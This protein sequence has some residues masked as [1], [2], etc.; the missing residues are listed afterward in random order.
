MPSLIRNMFETVF[1]QPQKIAVDGYFSTFTSYRPAFTTWQGG[2][3]EAELTRS[4]IESGAEHASKLKPEI[5]GNACQQATRSLLMQP[6]PWQTTPQF[7]KRIWTILQV[8]DTC[9][10]VRVHNS[11]GQHC[12]YMPVLPRKVEPY[13]VD[14]ELWLKLTFNGGL[15]R[16]EPWR[17]V[18]VMTRHQ[19]S[20]DLFGDSYDALQ[21]TLELMKAEIEAEQ[22]AIKQ[23]AAVRFIGKFSQILNPEDQRK[24]REEFNRQNLTPDNAGGI[25]VYDRAFETVEQVKPQSY[26]V[27]PAQMERIEKSV[28]RYF[29][30]NEDMVTNRADEETYNA[31][32]EGRIES[33]AVQLGMVLSCMTFTPYMLSCGN[34]IMLSANRLEFASMKTKLEVATALYDRGHISGNQVADIF[35]LPHYEGGD[36]HVIRGEYIDLDLIS[37]HTA[38]DA[39][40]ALELNSLLSQMEGGTDASITK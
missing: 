10:I 7:I 18:G 37:E 29:G 33:F 6:N 25:A 24:R 36:K 27:D 22:E 31:H 19:Y 5:A 16:Y 11:Q 14:G 4:V 2:L 12:G 26:T 20:S 38:D 8:N 21:P 35:Q 13:D 23:G 15:A 32:Y 3:Y 17:E 9:I 39:H 1:A 28:Y 34:Q 30:T 40:K